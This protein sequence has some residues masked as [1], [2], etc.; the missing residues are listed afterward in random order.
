MLP[1]KCNCVCW[2]HMHSLPPT[3]HKRAVFVLLFCGVIL[4]F[5]L[6]TSMNINNIKKGYIFT[7]WGRYFL[8]VSLSSLVRNTPCFSLLSP[9]TPD[10]WF[11]FRFKKRFYLFYASFSWQIMCFFISSFSVWSVCSIFPFLHFKCQ[12]LLYPLLLFSHCLESLG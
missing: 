10:F 12:K 11:F 2:L 6:R 1:D 5:L 4:T 3:P 9:F 7:F 8:K